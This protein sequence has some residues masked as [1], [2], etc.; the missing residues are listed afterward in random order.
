MGNIFMGNH[1][2]QVRP[3]RWCCSKT[4][5]IFLRSSKL[6]LV[7]HRLTWSEGRNFICEMKALTFVILIDTG[8]L[9]PVAARSSSLSGLLLC[10]SDDD[11]GQDEIYA[12][13][14]KLWLTRVL[15]I[16]ENS[17]KVQGRVVKY[18][19]ATIYSCNPWAMLSPSK[20]ICWKLFNDR[21]ERKLC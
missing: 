3:Q 9:H 2:Y 20:K 11:Q 13:V 4:R 6:S 15:S 1:V 18:G 14:V 7:I 5:Q 19:T 8:R 16:P 17:C 21:Q 10:F 12:R